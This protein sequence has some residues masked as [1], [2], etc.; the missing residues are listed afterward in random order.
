MLHYALFHESRFFFS[1]LNTCICQHQNTVSEIGHAHMCFYEWRKLDI[2]SYHV[3]LPSTF[4][5][6][7]WMLALR[8]ARLRTYTPGLF[9]AQHTPLAPPCRRFHIQN[10]CDGFLDLAL[11]LPLPPTL[12]AYSTTI[13]LVTLLSRL[14][15]L[16]I[17]IWVCLS[18]LYLHLGLLVDSLVIRENDAYGEQK[19]L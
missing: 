9:R 13:I 12:P 6:T 15:F 8:R 11:A 4:A 17:S 18:S 19:K 16:P 14:A 1:I 10:I 2:G 7:S 5:W 3:K